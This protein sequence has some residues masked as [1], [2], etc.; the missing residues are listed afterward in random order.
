[1]ID[2]DDPDNN[3]WLAVNQFTVVGGTAHAPA[4][5]RALRQRSAAGGDR[6]EERGRRER[7]DLDGVPA[8]SDLQAQIPSLFATNAVLVVSDGVRRASA[9]SARARSGSSHGARSPGARTRR[10]EAAGAAGGARGRIREAPLPRPGARTSSCSR[11]TGGGRSS[12][13]WRATTSSTRSTWQWKKPCAPPRRRG[14]SGGRA[15]GATR[16]A[17]ARRRAWRPA[18]RRGLAH[19]GLGQEPDD[20]VLCRAA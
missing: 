12:R 18:R 7:D 1:M 13:R 14:R 5:R 2:F 17:T 6:T 15:P 9:R 10:R 3:D 20:G 8:A 19:A 11:T 16:R 4:G